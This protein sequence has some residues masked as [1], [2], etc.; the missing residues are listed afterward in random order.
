MRRFLSV[1][2]SLALLLAAHP[3]H[4]QLGG[5]KKKLSDKVTGKKPDTTVAVA[6]GQGQARCDKS[7]MVITSDVVDRYLKGMAARDAE[8]KKIAR[9]PGPN[10]AYFAA[11]TKREAIER[12]K[13]EFDLRRGPDWE[14]YK[15]IYPKMAKGDQVAM[16]QQRALLDSLDPNKVEVPE[17]DWSAQQA[18]NKRLDSVAIAAAGISACDWGGNGIGDRIPMLVNVY[19]ADPNTKDLRGYGTPLEGAAVKARLNELKEVLG[20]NARAKGGAEFTEAEKAHIKEEDEK[21]AQSM[22]MTGDAYTDC[23]TKYQQEFYKKHQ[24][25]LEKASKDQDM[26]A[27]QRLSMLMAQESAKE[28]KKFSKDSDD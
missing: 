4:A 13:R 26:A 27:A 11:T 5:L 28:C 17:L 6:G 20:Y 21:L 7:T 12:R 10:Q 9:E 1:C 2:F 19:V 24:A 8:I 16:T 15:V 23:V 18:N 14:R 22:A 3:A 25:E